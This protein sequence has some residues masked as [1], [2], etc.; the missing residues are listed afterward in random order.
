[1]IKLKKTILSDGGVHLIVKAFIDKK[2]I[3]MVVDT[4]ASHSV[5]DVN[6]AKENLPDNEIILVE[7]PA[8]GI[9]SSVEVHKAEVMSF[10]IGKIILEDRLMALINFDPINSVYNREGLDEIQGILGGD[11]LAE[12]SGLIDYGKLKLKLSTN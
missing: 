9:G 1:M 3:R 7:D 11:V 10:K 8:Y 6:W 4:G 12:F 5:L 2:P